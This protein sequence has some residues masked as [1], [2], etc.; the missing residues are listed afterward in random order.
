MADPITA[1]LGKQGLQEYENAF[2]EARIDTDVLAELTSEDLAGIGIPLGDRKR[3]LK[4]AA[5]LQ[6][7]TSVLERRLISVLFV[8]L[9]GSVNISTQYDLEDYREIVAGYQAACSQIIT[10]HGG[11]VARKFGDGILAY[12]GFPVC[13]E[14]DTVRSARAALDIVAQVPLLKVPGGRVLQARAG[15]ATGLTLIDENFGN[16]AAENGQIFGDVPNLASRL[17]QMATPDSAVVCDHTR[18]ILGN[19]FVF[20]NLGHHT[21]KGLAEPVRAFGLIRQIE[22]ATRFHAKRKGRSEVMVNRDDERAL[23]GERAAQAR[24][25]SGQAIWIEGTAGIGKS[26][27]V[28]HSVETLS[29]DGFEVLHWQCDADQ[30][31]S[32]L[33][34]IA[35]TLERE[36]ERVVSSTGSTRQDGI[37]S[38]STRLDPPINEA[39]RIVSDILMR[40][41]SLATTQTAANSADV[42]GERFDVLLAMIAKMQS[43]APLAI[44]LEDSHWVDPTSRIFVNDLVSRLAD[45]RVLLICT[46]RPNGACI[47]PA[48]AHV[49]KIKLTP[50][51]EVDAKEILNNLPGIGKLSDDV[52]AYVLNKCDGIPLYIEEVTRAVVEDPRIMATNGVLELPDDVM[53]FGVSALPTSLLGSL[54]SRLDARSG[55]REVVSVAAAIGRRFHIKMLQHLIEIPDDRIKA[56]LDDLVEAQILSD[57]GKQPGERYAFDHEMMR[58]AAYD[59][60]LKDL[61]RDVHKQIPQIARKHFDGTAEARPANLAF[62]HYRAQ[63]W[64]EACA[65]WLE[66]AQEMQHFSAHSEAIDYCKRALEANSARSENDPRLDIEIE[67][68]ELLFISQE[69]SEWWSK[70]IAENLSRIQTL[71]TERGDVAELLTVVHGLAG[72]H[73]LEGRL[74]QARELAEHM[75]TLNGATTQF[76]QILGSRV[77]GICDFFSGEMEGA[78]AYFER[79]ALTASEADPDTLKRYYHANVPVVCRV[80]C[81]WADALTGDLEISSERLRHSEVLAFEQSDPLSQLYAL[82]LLACVYHALDDPEAVR[83]VSEPVISTAKEMKQPYWQ[84][85]GMILDGW[86]QAQMGA[87]AEGIE[88]IAKGI[89]AYKKTTAKQFIP[90]ARVLECQAHLAAGQM[91]DAH[92]MLGQIKGAA[93]EHEMRFIDPMIEALAVRVA[94]GGI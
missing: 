55:A 53:D 62:H 5:D 72:D 19:Q 66:A 91:N 48:A 94:R 9:V 40:A 31:N 44:V 18:E 42:W 8:D 43:D 87:F 23:I 45:M 67:I 47:L 22:D 79:A 33:H 76:A 74:G 63:M 26:M 69:A 71:R 41:S 36:I 34:P 29:K 65:C 14:S 88:A 38:W 73:L 52:S 56:I 64:A 25:G 46:S 80:F 89:T 12:F 20:E 1:F 10:R 86:A 13:R 32:A 57:I 3:I 82:C 70:D 15:V 16:D 27:L 6:S 68:R 51:A 11:K 24:G 37:R 17:H 78:K 83:R 92:E 4:A 54:L 35:V 61:R 75:L 39:E 30:Q 49:S 28:W 93:S 21:L 58:D 90:Y 81:D 7:T 2:R 85:W 77:L 60:L 84:A 59:I 50:L